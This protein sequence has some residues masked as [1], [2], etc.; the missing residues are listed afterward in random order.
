MHL[1]ISARM[2]NVLARQQLAVI[3]L[4]LCMLYWNFR[5]RYYD[6]MLSCLCGN[7]DVIIYLFFA[8]VHCCVQTVCGQTKMVWPICELPIAIG[9]PFE[10]CLN[11]ALDAMPIEIQFHLT[12]CPPSPLRAHLEGHAYVCSTVC[13]VVFSGCN[14]FKF[15]ILEALNL[16]S[17]SKFS[18]ANGRNPRVAWPQTYQL[19]LKPEPNVVF[20][21]VSE[22]WERE[23]WQTSAIFKLHEMDVSVSSIPQL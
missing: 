3:Y 1:F 6:T 7:A 14:H 8:T 15:G 13:V 11:V 22:P 10:G 19:L 5:V 4:F 20:L 2:E 17:F 23:H 16:S 21:L 18:A 12:Y 9:M